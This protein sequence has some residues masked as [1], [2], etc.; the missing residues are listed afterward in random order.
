MDKNSMVLVV[1]DGKLHKD[2]IP[3]RFRYSIEEELGYDIFA[4]YEEI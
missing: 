4:R 2:R 1:E 3:E